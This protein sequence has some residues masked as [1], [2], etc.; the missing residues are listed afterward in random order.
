MTLGIWRLQVVKKQKFYL[1]AALILSLFPSLSSASEAGFEVYQEKAKQI[2]D[3][4]TV[5]NT[6]PFDSALDPDSILDTVFDDLLVDSEWE[7]G[8]RTG[9]KKAIRTKLGQKI[10]A[11]MPQDAFAKLLRVKQAGSKGHALIRIDYGDNGNGYIDLH[12]EKDEEGTIRVTDW[13]DYSTGQLYTQSL[14]QVIAT[15]SPTPT[16]L[17]KVFDLATNKKDS[18]E[19][20][21]KLIELNNTQKHAEMVRFFLSLDEVYRESRLLNIISLQ[22]ANSSGDMK[23][24][25]QMLTNIARYFSDDENMA[26]QLLDYYF[27]EGD[28]D[29][30]IATAEQLQNSFGVEDAGLVTFKSNAYSE[31]GDYAQAIAEAKHAIELEPE[32]EYGYWSLITAQ[33]AAEKYQEA[34]ATAQALESGFNYDMGPDSLSGNAIYTGFLTSKPYR[35]WRNSLHSSSNE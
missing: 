2:S 5:R 28:Y 20:L 13:F 6:E 32:Y 26:Y 23:L 16:V 7:Q 27:L 10:V 24:Y 19:V 1:A 33:L 22:A 29:K 8:F 30:V 3:G 18:A 11:Q 35:T 21:T 17:G 15:M 25:Q 9:V 12:L 14:R 4:F 31:Q 34:V